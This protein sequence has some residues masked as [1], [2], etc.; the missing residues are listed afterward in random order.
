LFA[1]SSAAIAD[2]PNFDL[3]SA[4]RVGDTVQVTARLEVGGELSL[5]ADN[6]QIKRVPL[7]VT[8]TLQYGERLV[9]VDPSDAGLRRSIRTY[10]NAA[11]VIKLEDGGFEPKLRSDRSLLVADAAEGRSRLFS[12]EGSLTREELDLIDVVGNSI[13]LDGLLP[14]EKKAVGDHWKVDE[15]IVQGLLGL[16]AIAD[17]EVECVLSEHRG[18]VV[19]VSM[20]GGLRGAVD[21]VATEMELK[22]KYQFD[23]RWRGVTHL[24]LAVKEKRSIGH[25]GP[26]LDVTA[27]LNLEVR[28][29]KAPAELTDA[30]IAEVATKPSAQALL[31]KHHAEEAGLAVE[32]DRRWH[33][34]ADEAR[35]LVLRL[36]DRGD[37]L[38]QCN[39]SPIASRSASKPIS[40][41]QYQNDVKHSLGKRLSRIVSAGQWKDDAGQLV[42][43]VVAQGE[44]EK[45]PVQWHYY[46]VMHPSGRRVA[47]SL[48][49]EASLVERLGGA[50]RQLVDG[51][52]LDESAVQARAA[53]LKPGR[54][55]RR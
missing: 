23:L 21:G 2:E 43:Q 22:A 53:S 31:L 17:C 52:R 13:F 18:D 44:V 12:P 5:R 10:E 20:A 9:S 40:L 41:T 25:V 51:L 50:D 29:A 15:Q 26:G 34:T 38:A 35:L 39:I 42:Y 48:S 37:F 6:K 3:S 7:G 54:E 55:F 1:V 32:H 14:G 30:A 49:I 46:L 36:I 19:E 45:L 27:K 24:I 33:V 11:A 47:V 28:P 4:R 8:A 16:D